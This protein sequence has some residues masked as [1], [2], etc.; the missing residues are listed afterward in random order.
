MI[1]E[2]NWESV[3]VEDIF[4]NITYTTENPLILKTESV[5]KEGG[6]IKRIK[7]EEIF[8]LTKNDLL[9][10]LLENGDEKDIHFHQKGILRLFRKYNNKPITEILYG[11]SE[12]DW[13]I[14]GPD[15]GKIL[16]ISPNRFC[17][18]LI[19]DSRL[20]NKCILGDRSTRCFMNKETF[21]YYFDKDSI[22]VLVLI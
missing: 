1:T 7:K 15:V 6:E 11:L 19:I 9:S 16:E 4:N 5:F 2:L 22:S 12:D 8:D 20:E 18:N 14:M 17:G 13:V 10:E 3:C 21:E